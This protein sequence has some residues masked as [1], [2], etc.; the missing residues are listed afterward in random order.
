MDFEKHLRNG[1]NL[2][3]E[4]PAFFIL[5]GFIVLLL[6]LVSLGILAGPLL[7][8]YMLAMIVMLRTKQR[9]QF[10]DLQNGFARF[11]ELFYFVIPG[12]LIFIGFCLLII[13]GLVFMTWWIFVLPLMADQKLPWREAMRVSRQT[14]TEKGFFLHLLFILITSVAP[15]LLVNIAAAHFAPFKLLQLLLLPFQCGCVASLYLDCFDAEAVTFGA[16]SAEASRVPPE[17]EPLRAPP[18]PPPPGS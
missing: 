14:V 4:E 1:V 7:A 8:S 16:E 3:M 9:P 6:N 5:G 17:P 11:K 15:S 10:N 12:L 2:I 18:P 13:P